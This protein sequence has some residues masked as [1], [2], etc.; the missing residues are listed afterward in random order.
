[1]SG[2]TDAKI[3]ELGEKIDGAVAASTY[4]I[5]PDQLVAFA[6][7]RT[8]NI[9][10]ESWR[11]KMDVAEIQ[12]AHMNRVRKI[13]AKNEKDGASGF[14]EQLRAERDS[15][16]KI[17]EL[18]LDKFDY[19]KESA[20]VDGDAL[21]FIAADLFTFLVV[22]GGEAGRQR[23]RMLRDLDTLNRLTST[24]VRRKSGASSSGQKTGSGRS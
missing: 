9:K 23:T 15:T 12:D 10:P 8:W 20:S 1:M 5:K 6:A 4:G 16:K 3:R 2:K 7:G 21:A 19:E 14:A 18:V 11:Y 24:K 22:H 13:I 17:L